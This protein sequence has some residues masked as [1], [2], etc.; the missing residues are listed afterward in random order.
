MKLDKNQRCNI[1]TDFVNGLSVKKICKDYNV[2][3]T[4]IYRIL[5]KA[6]IPRAIPSNINRKYQIKE[7]YFK[8]ID[9][10]FK[11][12][13]LGF[14][15]ADGYINE[16]KNS[17]RLGLQKSD[18]IILEKLREDIYLNNDKPFVVSRKLN[19]NDLYCLDITNKDYIID[20]KRLGLFQNKTFLITF[21]DN[22][23]VPENLI[24]H[25]IRGYFDG[26]GCFT[27][28]YD[29]N[30]YI[31]CRFEIIGTEEF[32]KVVFSVLNVT[33]SISKV[34]KNI[35]RASTSK[36][37]NIENIIEFLYKDS[38]IYLERKYEKFKKWKIEHE[39]RKFDNNVS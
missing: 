37:K 30:K 29:K 28:Y 31:N 14:L 9:T 21:P 18:S 34:N 36:R 32:C 20:V 6:N 22:T 19:C 23:Q 11:A 4:T 8:L 26:D 27:W 12:Y 3:D 10:E 15:Y 16:S 38:N 39:K 33:P 2:V 17:I 35:I 25:F 7:G 1:C 24:R 13:F 5:K